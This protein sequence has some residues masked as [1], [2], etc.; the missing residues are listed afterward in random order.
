MPVGLQPDPAVN[1]RA[2]AGDAAGLAWAVLATGGTVPG[3]PGAA[4]PP[5]GGGTNVALALATGRGAGVTGPA[6]PVGAVLRSRRLANRLQSSSSTSGSC[7]GSPGIAPHQGP[8]AATGGQDGARATQRLAQ[9]A[10][11]ASCNRSA[12]R[13]ACATTGQELRIVQST[14]SLRARR[15]LARTCPEAALPQ[16]RTCTAEPTHAHV[17]RQRCHSS[18]RTHPQFRTRTVTHALVAYGPTIHACKKLIACLRA[19]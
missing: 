2:F 11:C 15:A 17:L 8:W 13:A 6:M 10:A 16:F 3:L 18:A 4:L 1:A 14:G 19:R 9:Q 5:A 12:T 7:S